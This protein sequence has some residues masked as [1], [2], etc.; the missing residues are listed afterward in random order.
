MPAEYTEFLA[1]APVYAR[2]QAIFPMAYYGF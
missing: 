2:M 1:L